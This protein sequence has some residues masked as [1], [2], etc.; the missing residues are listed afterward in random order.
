MAVELCCHAC[1]CLSIY[2]LF[3][4]LIVTRNDIEEQ[5]ALT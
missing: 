5:S 4:I 3:N 2:F 1:H